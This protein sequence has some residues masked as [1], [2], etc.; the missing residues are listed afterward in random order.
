MKV[1]DEKCK[2]CLK[3]KWYVLLYMGVKGE[4]ILVI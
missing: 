3:D 2:G 4:V 1:S